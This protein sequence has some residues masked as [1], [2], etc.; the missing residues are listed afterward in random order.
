MDD[1][2]EI[3]SVN[4]DEAKRLRD[5]LYSDEVKAFLDEAEKTLA[6]GSSLDWDVVSKV[7]YIHYY[8]TYFEKDDKPTQAKRAVDWITRALV[9]NPQHADFT[10]K[11][12]DMLGATG[13]YDAAVT[14][15]ERLVRQPDSPIVVRQWLG[16]FLL[17]IPGRLPDAVRYSEQYSDLA[18]GD[19]DALFNLA[20]AYA[21]AFC[22]SVPDLGPPQ[23][24]HDR[25]LDYLR[26]ALR[27]NPEYSDVIK[28]KWIEKGESFACFVSDKDFRT[29]VGLDAAPV[30]PAA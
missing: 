19:T 22:E 30:G 26:R 12:A 13:D 17:N 3:T 29:L 20:C 28:T 24:N 15:L 10:L 9:M 8:R 23:Q 27:R 18:G 1:V 4:K 6:D 2:D 7:A 14:V 11:L 16:Y 21:Q 25:A 5:I